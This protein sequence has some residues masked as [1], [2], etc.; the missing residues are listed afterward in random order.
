MFQLKPFIF[1]CFFSCKSSKRRNLIF[2]AVIVLAELAE[3]PQ[4]NSDSPIPFFHFTERLKLLKREGWRRHDINH[5]ETISDHMYRMSIMTMLAPPALSSKLNIP[6]CTKMA[7]VHDMAEA[8]VGDITPA[9]PVSKEEKAR[10]EAEVMDYVAT[11]LL[12]N[13]YG[14]HAGKG[15]HEAFLEY[16]ENETLE[17]K[18]VHDVDKIELLLQTIEYEK[19][20]GGKQK[21]S[22]LYRV[23]LKVQL[24]EMME[25]AEAIYKERDE[26]WD[27]QQ[28]KES[29]KL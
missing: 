9:D 8:L 7:L 6:L 23:G 14:G 13:V 29:Q 18:F 27:A 5:G 2:S 20:A 26:F 4:E 15:I 3:R 12:G 1:F 10:R 22:N 16:E 25:W 17:A 19:A 11:K 24:P 21:L 28:K